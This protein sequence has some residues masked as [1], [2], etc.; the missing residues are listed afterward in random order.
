MWGT[1]HGAIFVPCAPK[2]ALGYRSCLTTRL[3]RVLKLRTRLTTGLPFIGL[4]KVVLGGFFE[5]ENPTAET[6]TKVSH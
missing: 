2:M 3:L 4:G 1:K 6:N 5:A